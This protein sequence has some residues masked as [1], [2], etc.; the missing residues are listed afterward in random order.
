MVAAVNVYLQMKS[1]FG[2]RHCIRSSAAHQREICGILGQSKVRF[3]TYEI[4]HLLSCS[5]IESKPL[6]W[7]LSLVCIGC[8]KRLDDTEIARHLTSR[9]ILKLRFH[10]WVVENYSWVVSKHCTRGTTSNGSNRL[11]FFSRQW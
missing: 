3:C 5:T 11:N 4:L 6:Y 8:N 10:F 2:Q 7:T 9:A 1:S